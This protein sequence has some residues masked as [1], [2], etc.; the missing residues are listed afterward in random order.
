MTAVAKQN[1]SLNRREFL[2]YLGGASAVLFAVGSCGALSWFTQAQP[3]VG[4]DGTFELFDRW[5]PASGNNPVLFPEAPCYLVWSEEG[6]IALHQRCAYDLT[7]VKWV[8]ENRRYECPACGSKY[9][10]DGT[11]IEGPACRHL[12]R[13]L[14]TAEMMADG[15]ERSNAPDGAPLRVEGARRVILDTRISIP[16]YFDLGYPG[17]GR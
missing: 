11:Y 15:R 5:L 9:Q 10:F 12:D 6:V 16:Q 8:V 7:L 13:F 2:Y 3:R 4:R 14:L 17:A 1:D